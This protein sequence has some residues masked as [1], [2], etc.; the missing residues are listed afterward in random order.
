MPLV[1]KFLPA[2]H[3]VS[4]NFVQ[5]QFQ[6]SQ[7]FSYRSA[8]QASA[9][10]HENCQT[11]FFKLAPTDV[12]GGNKL[13][14]CSVREQQSGLPEITKLG[15][16]K[17]NDK[18][19]RP[20]N[21]FMLFRASQK[22][23]FES[24]GLHQSEISK[25]VGQMWR[26]LGKEEQKPFYEEAARQKQLHKAQHPDYKYTPRR[27]G[28]KVQPLPNIDLNH[29][30][31][32][33]PA[34]LPSNDN[35]DE[36]SL[37]DLPSPTPPSPQ[38]GSRFTHEFSGLGLHNLAS[39]PV[40]N[41]FVVNLPMSSLGGMQQ[42]QN[43][44][45]QEHGFALTIEPASPLTAAPLP[46]TITLPPLNK[47]G[48]MFKS[49]LPS[50]DCGRNSNNNNHTN[51]LSLPRLSIPE[52]PPLMTGRQMGSTTRLDK[53][54]TELSEGEPQTQSMQFFS[55]QQ[56]D[57]QE[58]QGQEQQQQLGLEHDDLQLVGLDLMNME[59]EADCDWLE[60]LIDP[61][62]NPSEEDLHRLS[63]HFESCQDL[64]DAF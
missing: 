36:L 13:S 23:K 56:S 44:P 41:S 48:A 63:C 14:T 42:R 20:S 49:K 9:V 15:R 1:R 37:P 21:A 46:S 47:R 11:E 58:Q 5:E 25:Q 4:N 35:D 12:F 34:F 17:K 61:T 33:S 10:H 50:R 3:E 39:S 55:E 59:P 2:H 31:D 7:T 53:Y 26:S 8:A 19:K 38:S 64:M 27:N 29:G 22:H 28:K 57:Y 52:T 40:S 6:T 51:C 60:S 62:M 18:I 54:L 24:S 43:R 45:Q 16:V 30:D 32:E